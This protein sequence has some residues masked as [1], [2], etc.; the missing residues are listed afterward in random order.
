MMKNFLR[1]NWILLIL[2]VI[3]VTTVSLTRTRAVDVAPMGSNSAWLSYCS[4]NGLDIPDDSPYADFQQGTEDIMVMYHKTIDSK[5]NDYIKMMIAGQAQAAQTGTPD[6]NSLPPEIDDTTGL[7]QDCTDTNYSTYCVASTLL[8]SPTYGYMTYRK[9][10]DCRRYQV[11]DSATEANAWTKWMTTTSCLGNVQS[12]IPPK[13]CTADQKAQMDKELV[14]RYQTASVLA[15][16]ARLEAITRE[17]DAAKRA[18]DQTLSAYDQLK[19][20][21]PMHKRYQQLYNQ[22]LTFRDK[23]VEIRNQVEQFPSKYIDATTTKCT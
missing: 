22:L 20:A 8:A 10:L 5:F 13:K 21:W 9:I 16:S 3:A 19:T 6:P 15:I 14:N 23:M 11:F 12:Y 18:L 2:A 7:P 1:H 4:A 17:K